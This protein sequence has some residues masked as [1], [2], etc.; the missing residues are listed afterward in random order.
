MTILPQ[1]PELR[2]L[3][4]I[5]GALCL[6][7]LLALDGAANDAAAISIGFGQA[8]LWAWLDR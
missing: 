1:S 4:A 2:A 7:G 6:F 5:N 3:V 8:A